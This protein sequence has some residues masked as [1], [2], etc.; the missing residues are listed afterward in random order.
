MFSA[1]VEKDGQLIDTFLIEKKYD[2]IFNEDPWKKAYSLVKETLTNK[3]YS[4][5]DV[6]I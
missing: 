5:S 3:K 6:L 1:F 4:F 2:S